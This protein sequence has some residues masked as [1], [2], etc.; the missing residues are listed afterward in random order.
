MN[1][2]SSERRQFKMHPALIY[3]TIHSQAG[4]LAKALAELV[5]NSVDANATRVDIKLDNRTYEIIDDGRGFKSAKEIDEFFATFGTPHNS[6]DCIYGKFRIGRG[7]AWSYSKNHWLSGQFEMLVDIKN[8]GLDYTLL[9][10]PDRVYK[11]CTI[12]GEMY[13]ALTP[14]ELQNC[15][16][17]LRQ[18][19]AYVA[20]PVFLNGTQINKNPADCKWDME[21][22]DAYIKLKANGTLKVY[23]LGVFVRE[24]HSQHFGCGGEVVSKTALE[25]NTAR[26]DVLTAKCECWKRIRKFLIAQNTDK[27]IRASRLDDGARQNL[28]LQFRNGDVSYD[29]I[30]DTK[31]VTLG[32]R[33]RVSLKTLRG[34]RTPVTLAPEAGSRVADIVLARKMALVL[35]QETLD[36]FGVDSVDR[37]LDQIATL[38]E[39]DSGESWEAD[40]FRQLARVDFS[41]VAEMFDTSQIVLSEKELDKRDRILLAAIRTGNEEFVMRMNFDRSDSGDIVVRN[42]FAGKSESAA[43]WTNGSSTVVFNLPELRKGNDGLHGFSEICLTL[44][45]EY[46]HDRNDSG[47]HL[48]DAEFY[49]KFHDLVFTPRT[50]VWSAAMTMF[51]EYVKGLQAARIR[52]PRNL[53][54]DADLSF[55]LD[56]MVE[57][58]AD[59]RPTLKLV[60][61]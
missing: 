45:H 3:S 6:G 53:L 59:S 34:T 25:V 28:I 1:T 27:N 10:H 22:A 12:S 5:C 26:N 38:L 57:P 60:A 44:L 7:Q 52:I 4:T 49:E 35:S 58:A 9:E 24:Y 14:S 61:Q 50:P 55:R 21:T 56:S 32:N 33:Q 41:T 31:V 29:Q 15:E 2:V 40:K 48:H 42:I 30:K 51:R 13:D 16:R 8:H 54:R 47:S 23:N 20:V 19:V 39:K 18:L 46:L 11:G 43:A 36:E 17:D 37:F